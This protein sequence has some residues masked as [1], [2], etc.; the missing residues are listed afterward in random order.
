MSPTVCFQFISAVLG[1]TGT[2]LLFF[3]SYMLHP[4]EGATWGNSETAARNDATRKKNARNLKLQK[5]G[6]G[7]LCLSF[8]LQLFAILT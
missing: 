3:F 7:L 2:A 4:Y 6:F 8:L 1:F 5:L